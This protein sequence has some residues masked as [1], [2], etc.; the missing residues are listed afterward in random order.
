[1]KIIKIKQD[2]TIVGFVGLKLSDFNVFGASF[3]IIKFTPKKSLP[4]Q[5]G[6]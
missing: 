4:M 6:F 3:L 2:S 1:M 5:E